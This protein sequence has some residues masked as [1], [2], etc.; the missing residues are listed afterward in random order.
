MW[1]VTLAVS[2]CCVGHDDTVAPRMRTHGNAAMAQLFG[3]KFSCR[4][5]IAVELSEL[6]QEMHSCRWLRQQGSDLI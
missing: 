6:Q 5:A 4:S 1:Q 3:Y 2:S